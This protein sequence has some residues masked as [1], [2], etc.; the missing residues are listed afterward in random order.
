MRLLSRLLAPVCVLAFASGA[1]A[2][3]PAST[4]L[5][6]PL[7]N[8]A[9]A[10]VGASTF[11]A[12]YTDTAADLTASGTGVSL[13]PG[14]QFHV[15]TCIKVHLL[16]R[17]R[18][19]KCGE[20]SV[21]TRGLTVAKVV[22]APTVR[23]ST[24][25]PAAGKKGYAS[26]IVT[27]SSRKANGNYAP[28]ASSWP[29][30]GLSHSSI[31]L[32]AQGA[33]TGATPAS[34]GVLRSNGASGGINSG[35]MDS[36]CSSTYKPLATAPGEGVSTTALGT[37]PAYYEVGEPTGAFAGQAPKGVMLVIHGGGWH[38]NGPGAVA[39]ERPDADR[40]RAR[41][42]RTLNL[43]YRPCGPSMQDVQWFYDKAVATWGT[44][45]PYCAFGA[46]AGGTMAALLSTTRPAMAC[47]VSAAGPTDALSLPE[48]RTNH[49]NPTAAADGP[50]WIHNFMTAMA[51]PGAL[52]FWSPALLEMNA[53]VLWASAANDWL[54]PPAQG[55]ELREKMLAT[56]PN[57]YVEVM[58]LDAG[59]APWVHSSV[60][61]ASLDAFYAAEERLTAP[62][63]S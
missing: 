63:V 10:T 33:T 32:P 49:P 26:Y 17:S 45:L 60:S 9:G 59:T 50:K 5:K 56:N 8:S 28:V 13:A 21:D 48:Q 36:F 16:N 20:S 23:V 27:T 40:W 29:K 37:G 25:R 4:T 54:I 22:A 52:Y 14:G 12:G 24:P 31:P 46:S 57:A 1:H 43:S 58:T 6:L 38:M 39:E 11:T 15:T 42:W 51:G 18:N 2:S 7:L 35:E 53:R 61:Q 41:G 34:E 62:L 55:A 30:L 44:S 19:T 3:I 47:A